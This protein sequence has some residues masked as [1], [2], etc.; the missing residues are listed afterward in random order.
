[1]PQ[2]R[3]EDGECSKALKICGEKSK[4]DR[5]A[6][7]M[8]VSIRSDGVILLRVDLLVECKDRNQVLNCIPNLGIRLAKLGAKPA[9]AT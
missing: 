9:R 3:S 8:H 6:P 1:M 5:L 2:S 7:Q 4:I